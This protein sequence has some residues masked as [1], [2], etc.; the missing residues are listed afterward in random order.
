MTDWKSSLRADPTGW[1]LETAAPPTKYRVLTELLALPPEDP[2][3]V[4]AKKEALAWSPA[5]KLI[6]GQRLDGSW[7]GAI[8]LGDPRK[9][10]PST[11]FALAQLYEHGYDR[12]SPAVRKALKLLKGFLTQKRDLKLYEF[13]KHVKA[14]ILRERY[15]RWLLRIL[16][17]GLVQRAGPETEGKVMEQVLDLLDRVSAFVND[18]I[19]RNPV[20]RPGTRLA[21]IRRE[22]MRDGYSFIPDL[23]T[24]RVF[25]ATPRLLDSDLLKTKLK[26]IYDYVISE[27]YQRHG[28]AIGMVKTA[29]G[30]LM[31]GF[32]I[33]LRPV[34]HYV[35]TGS[36]DQ[37]FATLESFA[38]LGL[39]NRYPVLM[40]YVEWIV[41]QQQKDGRWEF[42]QKQ[43]DA[44]SYWSRLIR[45]E[46]D[47]RSPT[48]ASADLTFRIVLIL[49]YQWERQIR[50]LD[51]GEESY[52]M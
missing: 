26:K 3:V 41:N 46:K 48:R 28:S 16:A 11:E 43:F 20:E 36:V 18:P 31:K 49:R 47:W 27:N 24:M 21:L 2:R 51:R 30:S 4:A 23:L 52:P 15:Y 34:D 7:G 12:S 33:E 38:R 35:R 50:M 14:D 29:R 25:A 39:V 42:S 13:Q 19:S 40:G 5:L 1:L 37:L 22:S 6:R 45:L 44:S 10:A 17:L 9:P 32:G 8:S